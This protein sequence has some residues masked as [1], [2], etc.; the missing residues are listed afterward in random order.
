MQYIDLRD[1]Y[2]GDIGTIEILLDL[3]GWMHPSFNFRWVC[4]VS[5]TMAVIENLYD[6]SG[7]L[8]LRCKVMARSQAFFSTH[9]S[10]CTKDLGQLSKPNLTNLKLN[11]Y[12]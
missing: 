7:I 3:I 10:I 5:A 12:T 11:K 8:S 9:V 6:R 4:E 1:R 2:D